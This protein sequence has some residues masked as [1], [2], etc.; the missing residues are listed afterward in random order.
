MLIFRVYNKN[1]KSQVFGFG[2]RIPVD[3]LNYPLATLRERV[4]VIRTKKLAG[5]WIPV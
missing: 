1:R 3:S 2:N 4:A 5:G